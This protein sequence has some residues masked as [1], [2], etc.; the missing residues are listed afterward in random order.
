MAWPHVG[1]IVAHK[2]TIPPSD[3]L[4]PPGPN[5]QAFDAELTHAYGNSDWKRDYHYVA[6]WDDTGIANAVDDLLNKVHV[7]VIVVTGTTL[8]EKVYNVRN[9][10]QN[11]PATRTWLIMATD[12]GDWVCDQFQT[13][14]DKQH[15]SGTGS[16]YSHVVRDR[17][18]RLRDAFDAAH[19][20]TTMQLAVLQ[21]DPALLSPA[22]QA[23]KDSQLADVQDEL[24]HLKLPAAPDPFYVGAP[25][26]L[27]DPFPIGDPPDDTNALL[28]LGDATT[29]LARADIVAALSDKYDQMMGE[30][31]AFVDAGGTMSYGPP[32]PAR[33]AEAADYVSQFLKTGHSHA[34][35]C[36]WAPG[37]YE[38]CP[39]A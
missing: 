31:C 25:P 30:W 4:P 24:K 3:P 14:W 12:D 33:Y 20:G 18:Q 19:P 26:T 35:H 29:F 17:V 8:G 36:N 38:E 32:M 39:P 23:E 34:P 9:K 10:L 7:D 13:R 28:V 21:A 2:V 6:P 15:V 27:D 5:V 16:G 22:A 11:D 37:D 1:G